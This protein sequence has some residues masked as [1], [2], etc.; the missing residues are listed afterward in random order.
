[1]TNGVSH[2]E[3]KLDSVW[4]WSSKYV[5]HLRSGRSSQARKMPFLLSAR[6]KSNEIESKLE[7]YT[8]LTANKMILEEIVAQAITLANGIDG[9]GLCYA[10]LAGNVF[11][12]MSQNP[13]MRDDEQQQQIDEKKFDIWT[14]WLCKWKIQKQRHFDARI[15]VSKSISWTTLTLERNMQMYLYRSAVYFRAQF[16]SFYCF[17]SATLSTRLWLKMLCIF[18]S[19]ENMQNYGFT[20]LLLDFD[21]RM[22]NANKNWNN[23]LL[24]NFLFGISVF[25]RRYYVL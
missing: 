17:C 4:F 18:A 5:R 25:I 1:M 2:N 21:G 23:I 16:S 11:V 24:P 10:E 8:H 15:T 12:H 19:A 7:I 14:I 6:T 13:R 22:A 9:M 3:Y 20:T